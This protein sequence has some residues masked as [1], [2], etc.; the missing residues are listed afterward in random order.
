MSSGCGRRGCSSSKVRRMMERRK[1]SSA[2]ASDPTSAGRLFNGIGP[3]SRTAIGRLPHRARTPCCVG[4]PSCWSSAARSHPTAK[5]KV[6]RMPCICMTS[7]FELSQ[8]ADDDVSLKLDFTAHRPPPTLTLALTLTLTLTLTLPH[9]QTHTPTARR[10]HCNGTFGNWPTDPFDPFVGAILQWPVDLSCCE[11]HLARTNCHSTSAHPHDMTYAASSPALVEHS[12]LLILQS[13]SHLQ[14]RVGMAGNDAQAWLKAKSDEMALTGSAGEDGLACPIDARSDAGPARSSRAERG[15]TPV[16]RTQLHAE[17]DSAAAESSINRPLPPRTPAADRCRAWLN[18]AFPLCDP[19]P[20]IPFCPVCSTRLAIVGNTDRSRLRPH[21]ADPTAPSVLP[22][23]EDCVPTSSGAAPKR[24]ET[25]CSYPRISA[26]PSPAQVGAKLCASPHDLQCLS[27]DPLAL[28]STTTSD[29]NDHSTTSRWS[30]GFQPHQPR[31]QK[32]S[33]TPAKASIELSLTT[34]RRLIRK[35][36]PQIPSSHNADSIHP[37]DTASG[38]ISPATLDAQCQ[39]ADSWWPDSLPQKHSAPLSSTSQAANTSANPH[40]PALDPQQPDNPGLDDQSLQHLLSILHYAALPSEGASASTQEDGTIGRNN[41]VV[42]ATGTYKRQSH[43]NGTP[44]SASKG[45]EHQVQYVLD[46]ATLDSLYHALQAAFRHLSQKQVLGALQRTASIRWRAEAQLR[47][48]TAA[49]AAETTASSSRWTRFA[50]PAAALGKAYKEAQRSILPPLPDAYTGLYLD[51]DHRVRKRDVAVRILSNAIWFVRNY[52]P[53]AG[54]ETLDASA[55]ATTALDQASSPSDPASQDAAGELMPPSLSSIRRTSEN[56]LKK[57]AGLPTFLSKSSA[58][59]ALSGTATPESA[60]SDA[61]ANPEAT[62][63]SPSTAATPESLSIASSVS[64]PQVPVVPASESAPDTASTALPP[65]ETGA[66]A[67][68]DPSTK[69]NNVGGEKSKAVEHLASLS[70]AVGAAMRQ[71]AQQA[72]AAAAAHGGAPEDWIDAPPT[73][74]GARRPSLHTFVSRSEAEAAETDALEKAEKD[75]LAEIGQGCNEWAKM[76]VCRL[77][78]SISVK[79]DDASGTIRH[80]RSGTV[81]ARDAAKART[82]GADTSVGSSLSTR[83]DMTAKAAKVSSRSSDDLSPADDTH[84]AVAWKPD[85]YEGA[86]LL[87]HL[88]EHRP[89]VSLQDEDQRV[90]LVG[91]RAK[92]SSVRA[93]RTRPL[94]RHVDAARIELPHRLG[95]SSS[96]TGQD[97]NAH[98]LGRRAAFEGCQPGSSLCAH[99]FVLSSHDR[100]QPAIGFW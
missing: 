29:Y 72:T 2:V 14:E 71:R 69:N 84:E 4:G 98:H 20:H 93:T 25:A 95:R 10:S 67:T 42:S 96:Q 46:Q 92:A 78:A 38:L 37:S 100:R 77:C 5:S 7:A 80:R 1:G 68:P 47:N 12:A 24:S 74:T 56:L 57:N 87:S 55:P 60:R 86:E 21:T 41:V 40:T 30:I 97:P 85:V 49:Q 32:R 36:L 43:L 45:A 34:R 59:T 82:E 6:T 18:S 22:T 70:A 35:P 48:A 13:V 54:V 23:T 81:T 8:Q 15:R 91:G 51:P 19:P 53:A 28:A 66:T 63:T 79:G 99:S 31:Q 64:S 3:L 90:R 11:A 9:R 27:L 94:R 26:S 52:G 75:Y 58:T 88:G 62:A 83:S 44:A 50:W 65:P 16:A 89:G 39:R 73:T 17:K 33:I 76:V 61:A